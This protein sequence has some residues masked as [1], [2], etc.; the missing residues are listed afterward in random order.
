MWTLVYSVDLIKWIC[1]GHHHLPSDSNLPL[2]SVMD[3]NAEENL[4]IAAN[5]V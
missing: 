1:R 2:F 4:N 3:N 5:Y